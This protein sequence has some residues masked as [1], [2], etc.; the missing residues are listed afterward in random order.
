MEE[1]TKEEKERGSIVDGVASAITEFPPARISLAV[2]PR[3]I[4]VASRSTIKSRKILAMREG[5][6]GR[7]GI[8]F[9]LQAKYA[10]WSCATKERPSERKSQP[11][12]RDEG[13]TSRG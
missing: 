5:G 10:V 3:S 13:K 12:M 9:D 8:Q 4:R 6:E 1:R 7:K 2:F 11:E